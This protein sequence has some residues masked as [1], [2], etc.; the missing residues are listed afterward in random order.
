[1][2][3]DKLDGR[4]GKDYFDTKAAEMR[5]AQA[6]IIRDIQAHQSAN[7]NYIEE[8]VQ[9]LELAHNAHVL[10]ESQPAVEKGKLLA[11]VL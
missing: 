2:Y 7:R 8:G 3:E 5:A 1:M 6:S 4:A 9:L 10:F 11:F